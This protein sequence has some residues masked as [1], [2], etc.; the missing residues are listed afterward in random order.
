MAGEIIALLQTWERSRRSKVVL[1]HAEWL[2]LLEYV[3]DLRMLLFP[4]MRLT[5]LWKTHRSDMG[6]NAIAPATCSAPEYVPGCDLLSAKGFLLPLGLDEFP[7][8]SSASVLELDLRSSDY[9]MGA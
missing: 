2:K 8:S 1:G 6:T 5:Q 9:E 3:E 4:S 7:L